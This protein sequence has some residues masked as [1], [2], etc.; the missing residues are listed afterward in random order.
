MYILAVRVGWPDGVMAIV[1]RPATRG[2]SAW[3]SSRV[4]SAALR[5]PLC[6]IPAPRSAVIQPPY[7][8]IPSQTVSLSAQ[9]S[10]AKSE[11]IHILKPW[12]ASGI[13]GKKDLFGWPGLPGVET[14]DVDGIDVVRLLFD[15]ESYADLQHVNGTTAKLQ[16]RRCNQVM[17][18]MVG[19]SG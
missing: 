18:R 9:P 2:S 14:S 12:P 10:I 5:P 8:K 17:E 16:R 6:H 3:D 4:E 1:W 19:A 7:R 15:R 13:R 11:K